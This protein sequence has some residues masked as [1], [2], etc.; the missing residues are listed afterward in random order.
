MPLFGQDLDQIFL[1]QPVQRLAD[2]RAA[3]L[4]FL[5]QRGLVEDRAGLIIAVKELFLDGGIGEC[6]QV[7]GRHGRAYFQQ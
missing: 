4:Q 1:G 3:D 6:F 5:A 7:A 2:R